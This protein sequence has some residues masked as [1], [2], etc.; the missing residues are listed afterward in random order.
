MEEEP[1]PAY[2]PNM[3]AKVIPDSL[4]NLKKEFTTAIIN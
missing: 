2:W 1:T 4:F 3:T